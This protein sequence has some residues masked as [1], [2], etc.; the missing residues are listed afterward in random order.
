MLR[1]HVKRWVASR[2]VSFE[3]EEVKLLCEGK[4]DEMRES[5]WRP[6][7]DHVKRTEEGYLEIEKIID[8]EVDRL[9][10]SLGAVPVTLMILLSWKIIIRN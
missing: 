4:F 7:S 6:V 5:G 8:L 1:S 2:N 9:I 10:I 3:T